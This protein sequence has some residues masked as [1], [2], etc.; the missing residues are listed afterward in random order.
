MNRENIEFLADNFVYYTATPA[1][2]KLYKRAKRLGKSIEK[3][4]HL[5]K[6][7]LKDN[8]PL[9]GKNRFRKT[10]TQSKMPFRR[11]LK[12]TRFRRTKSY[13]YK[14]RPSFR[15]KT[16]RRFG[17]AIRHKRSRMPVQKKLQKFLASS[18]TSIHQ[19]PCHRANQSL[20]PNV[21]KVRLVTKKTMEVKGLSGGAHDLIK[22]FPNDIN[23]PFNDGDGTQAP[24]RDDLSLLYKRAV[25]TYFKVYFRIRND[26]SAV[27]YPVLCYAFLSKDSVGF[28]MTD[29]IECKDLKLP[30]VRIRRTDPDAFIA[31]K[32]K[33]N[34]I[35]GDPR[36]FGTSNLASTAE[37]LTQNI[38]TGAPAIL[39]A[40]KFAFFRDDGTGDSAPLEQDHTLLM[41]CTI[42]QETI[43]F[44]RLNI[45][46]T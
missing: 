40:C 26:A 32:T 12:P 14:R 42:V 10:K 13:R 6:K 33:W 35:K 9:Y 43:V 17:K 22:L 25:C 4:Y 8:P 16:Y 1:Q 2:N 27:T 19:N 7:F 36:H 29:R 39:V 46:D 24:G 41:D 38:L 15:R 11:S 28:N 45:L 21:R 23:N 44:S 18:I 34:T 37:D 20:F 31:S 3:G 5:T 30:F